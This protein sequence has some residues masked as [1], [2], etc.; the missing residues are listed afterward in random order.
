MNVGLL[1]VERRKV[2]SPCLLWL[3]EHVQNYKEHNEIFTKQVKSL[4]S[5]V[6]PFLSLDARSAFE[7]QSQQVQ[8]Q[9]ES[10]RQKQLSRQQQNEDTD[11]VDY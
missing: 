10:P 2:D 11:Y 5:I 8:P 3:E 1:Q 4:V 6:L 7:Q 9:Q